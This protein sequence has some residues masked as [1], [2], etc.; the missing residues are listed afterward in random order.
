[1]GRNYFRMTVLRTTVVYIND[2]DEDDGRITIKRYKEDKFGWDLCDDLEGKL[3]SSIYISE[4]GRIMDVPSSRPEIFYIRDEVGI[5]MLCATLLSYK[6][7]EKLDEKYECPCCK[8]DFEYEDDLITTHCEHK[9]C[10]KCYERVNR[11]PL[12]RA[13][14]TE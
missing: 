10:K 1:M 3:Y 4:K 2:E 7:V 13:D 9:Y 12:C 5:Y 14:L 6:K 11:C 8:V